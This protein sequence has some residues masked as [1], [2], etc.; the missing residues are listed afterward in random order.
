MGMSIGSRLV[1]GAHAM[2]D[3]GHSL[4]STRPGYLRSVEQVV[5]EMRSLEAQ[6]P[7][8]VKVRTIGTTR[9][10]REIL[11]MRL[12]N[13]RVTANKPLVTHLAGVHAREIA[14]PAMTMQWARELVEGF[15]TDAEATALLNSRRIDIIPVLSADAH[16]AVE[17]GFR[18]SLDGHGMQRRNGDIFG[19]VDLNRNFDD[20]RWGMEGAS[21]HSF[22]GNY[23]G[24]SAASEPE[25]RALQDHLR[26]EPPGLFIDW[27]SYGNVVG[28]PSEVANVPPPDQAGLQAVA[29]RLAELNG[30]R[31]EPTFAMYPTSGT[32]DSFAYQRLGIPAFVIETGTRFH[33]TERQFA[34]TYARNAPVLAFASKLAA[35]PYRLARTADVGPV[36]VR[37]A[38]D[39]VHLVAEVTPHAGTS[40]AIVGAELVT[41]PFAAVGSGVAL[42]V[43]TGAGTGTAPGASTVEGALD[44]GLLEQLHGYPALDGQ[45]QL[46]YVRARMASGDWS[47]AAATWLPMRA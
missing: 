29:E 44:G 45:R 22:M 46:A 3:I 16:A 2:G 13:D 28:Y 5:A 34:E 12:T 27:H 37:A 31:P 43:V 47:P 11:A 30:Y 4:V 40:Q 17:R 9:E 26:Q 33:Q 32:T 14:N 24:P 23:R 38:N 19:G 15:G 42:H 35:D 18:G 21:R 20:G 6:Y 39:G 7:N 41:D 36:A 8:L 10:G 25:T 1:L